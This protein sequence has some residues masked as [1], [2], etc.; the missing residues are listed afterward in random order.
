MRTKSARTLGDMM[1]HQ[2][3]KAVPRSPASPPPGLKSN[4]YPGMVYHRR[5]RLHA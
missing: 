2:Y 1:F 5:A 4:G 3:A